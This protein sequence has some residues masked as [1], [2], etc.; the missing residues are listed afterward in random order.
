MARTIMM[1]WKNVAGRIAS[2]RIWD[3]FQQYK[4]DK[5][6]TLS[7]FLV[8]YHRLRM[9]ASGHEIFRFDAIL[10]LIPCLPDE[11]QDWATTIA[12]DSIDPGIGIVDQVDPLGFIAT[13]IAYYY[14]NLSPF[15]IL[16]LHWLIS[17]QPFTC[18]SWL[19][20]LYLHRD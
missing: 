10:L 6:Q 15:M 17:F 14:L 12:F 16:L 19:K 2:E 3:R 13:I 9:E 20:L 18:I 5:Q 11:W 1:A 8:Q 7:E 4:M